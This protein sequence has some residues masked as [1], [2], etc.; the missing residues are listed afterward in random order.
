MKI[1]NPQHGGRY[2]LYSESHTPTNEHESFE[3]FYLGKRPVKTPSWT[4]IKHPEG[5][6]FVRKKGNQL[7]IYC[8]RSHELKEMQESE[9][10]EWGE[11]IGI[12]V[13]KLE[14]P[15]FSQG[16]KAY[17]NERIKMWEELLVA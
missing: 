8:T 1:D 2:L 12:P 4:K 7:E 6:I 14:K 3:G 5:H 15:N 11:P 9:D 10:G 16:E 17:L 13:V